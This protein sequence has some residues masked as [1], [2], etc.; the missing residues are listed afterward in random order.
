MRILFIGFVWPEPTSSAAGQNIL[1]YMKTCKQNQWQ[2]YFLC[3]AEQ[4]DHSQNLTKLGI[5][6][7]HCKLN[8][9]SFNE[10]VKHIQPDIVIFDRFLTF[11]QFAWRVKEASPNVMTIIDAED[12]HFL[13]E[14]RHLQLKSENNNIQSFHT[15]D[16]V[17]PNKE[18]LY[19]KLC[20]RELSC[21]YQ[22]DLTL[23]LSDFE[24]LL[25]QSE[26]NVPSNQIANIPFILS[27]DKQQISLPSFD[28]KQDFVF[29]GNF[30]HSPNYH[31]AKILAE[32]IW[33]HIRKTLIKKLGTAGKSIKCHVYGAYMTPKAKQL[34]KPSINFYMHGFAKNQFEVITNARVMLAPITFGAGVKGKLLD[35]MQVQTPS[36]TTPLGAEGISDLPWPGF[37]ANDIETFIQASVEYYLEQ[38]LHATAVTNGTTILKTLYN[39]EN[40]QRLFLNTLENK[41]KSLEKDR[42]KN[43]MQR[44]LSQQAFQANKYM[45]QW[46]EAKNK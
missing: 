30:R 15:S 11:E 6:N 34:D 18:Y 27:N 5:T 42:T 33:P 32:N 19:N 43:F 40:N 23:L 12:L 39:I 1:S 25:L 22:A 7:D 46:I 21:I 26:F 45:S 35:A 31:A 17:G 3:P 37:I 2:V 20:L 10:Q 4:N 24:S 13:R 41:A 44:M 29:I 38:N 9:S 8:C 36:I 16:A 28:D 14:A